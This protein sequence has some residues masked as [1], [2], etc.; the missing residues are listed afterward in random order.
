MFISQLHIQNFR[1]IVDENFDIFPYTT[2]IGKNNSGKS[3]V[4]R[5]LSLLLDG[6]PS[7]INSQDFYNE[8]KDILIE[9]TVKNVSNYLPLIGDKHRNK[10][11]SRTKDDTIVVRRIGN[12]DDK[13]LGKIEIQDPETRKFSTVTGIDAA[14]KQFLPEVIFIEALIDPNSEAYGKASATLGK[15]IKQILE[16]IQGEIA[17]K[18]QNSF[19]ELSPMLNPVYNNDGHIELDKRINEL[20]HIENS[21]NANVQNVVSD[22]KARLLINLPGVPDIMTNSRIE[23]W[24]GGVWTSPEL[25]GQGFQRILYVALLQ[26]LAEQERYS[27]QETIKRPY[28]LLVEEPEICL[29][30]RLQSQMRDALHSISHSNPVMIVTHAP[31]MVVQEKILD[32]IIITKE[33]SEDGTFQ[34]NR[35]RPIRSFIENEPDKRIAH[36]MQY[37]RS[38]T[39]LFSER[40]VVVEGPSDILLLEAIWATI[41]NKQPEAEG[42]GFL[43]AGSKDVVPS[44]QKVLKGIGLC[45]IGIVDFDFIWNGA[46]KCL[47]S[48]KVYSKFCDQFWQEACALALAEQKSREK[49]IKKEKKCEAIKLVFERFEDEIISITDSLWT[50]HQ[51]LV[52]KAGEI[53]NYVGLTET[54]KGQY[55]KAAREIRAKQRDVTSI[56]ELQDIFSKIAS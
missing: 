26:T 12:S 22:S 25:K 27:D 44:C 23:L 20:R 33:P 10:I 4:M 19:R 49:K 47:G 24:D 54:S 37:Q 51:I 7:S 21:L 15:L 14:F 35:L 41:R 6:S 17:I 9:A 1:S 8:N 53:E 50:E 30:P 5:A 3:N 56:Q 11:E 46:G 42:V 32:T 48:D 13:K 55:A 28:Y 18:L 16:P 52:L 45:T 31:S 34:T 39:F 29:H 43:D 2:L 38:S 40:I 36:L